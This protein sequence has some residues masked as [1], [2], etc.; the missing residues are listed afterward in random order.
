MDEDGFPYPK[1]I[2]HCV[3]CGLCVVQCPDYAI[4]DDKETKE[5]LIEEFIL[6]E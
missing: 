6:E 1:D 2:A 5:K 3:N 4:V